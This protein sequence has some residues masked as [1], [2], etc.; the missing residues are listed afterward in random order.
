[1]KNISI[2]KIFKN[3]N[4]D[5]F[6]PK[7]K[8]DLTVFFWAVFFLFIINI[9]INYKFSRKNIEVVSP[10]LR[11]NPSSVEIYRTINNIKN[12]Q[13][14]KIVFL[15]G[16]ALWGSTLKNY[17][18][19]IPFLFSKKFDSKEWSVYNLGI[20]AARPLDMLLITKE[21]EGEVDI[22]IADFNYQFF[23][24]MYDINAPTDPSAFIRI[25][26]LVEDAYISSGSIDIEV[27]TCLKENNLDH[28]FKDNPEKQLERFFTKFIPVLY[29]KDDINYFLFKKHLSQ[30]IQ[31]FFSYI[32]DLPKRNHNYFFDLFKSGEELSKDEKLVFQEHQIYDVGLLNDKG[33]NFCFTKAYATLIRNSKT[34]TFI[35]L[36]P[37][38]PL[39]LGSFT[40]S[41]TYL[42]NNKKI[43]DLFGKQMFDLSS[44]VP[45]DYFVDINHL[46]SFGTHYFTDL[47]YK[48]LNFK[49]I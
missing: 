6:P 9:Y 1:M 15:G 31:N 11:Y 3:R 45:A 23:Q 32:L 35:Y 8:V 34:P 18:D 46:N 36:L 7:R 30:F 24:S 19:T 43:M 25:K 17:Q 21:L 16:S 48:K 26:S 33:I 40:S 10:R 49:Q 37:Q 22:I 27:D 41:T 44:A 47:L 12:D 29:Y 39:I 38:N 2:F 42:Q 20:N 14:K 4:Q 13:K 28:F 5:R